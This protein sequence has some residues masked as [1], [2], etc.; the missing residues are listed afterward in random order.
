MDLNTILDSV[1]VLP[2]PAKELFR[3][4]AKE[5]QLPKGS[6]LFQQHKIEKRLY[7][8]K[9]GLVRA[10]ASTPDHEVTF[11]FG[12]EGS[13]V[14][15]MKNYISNEKSYEDIVLL[16]D[17]IFYEIHSDILQSL[18]KTNIDIANWGRKFAELELIRAEERLIDLQ[19]KT[20]KERYTDLITHHPDII[21]RVA[22]GHIAS[23]L[24]ITQVSL[25][26]IRADIR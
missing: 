26:R 20:A 21:Q 22:L 15:S 12:M 11:W 1:Y 8:L 13:I 10:Y 9:K 2:S 25:S 19:F 4:Y 17:C 23:Y 7:F 5:V 14:L 24:G 16:E 6:L 3:T 18:F